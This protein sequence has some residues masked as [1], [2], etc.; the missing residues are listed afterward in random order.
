MDARSI[1]PT[2]GASTFRTTGGAYDAFMGDYSERSSGLD[3]PRADRTSAT[4]KH[5]QHGRKL[6]LVPR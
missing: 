4:S 6:C 1:E 2:E 5:G 3:R